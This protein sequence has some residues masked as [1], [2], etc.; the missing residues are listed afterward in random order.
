MALIVDASVAVKWF[1]A[2]DLHE[3]ARNLLTVDEPL[4]APDILATEFANVMWVKTRRREIEPE[5]AAR[6]LGA[7]VQ[8]VPL[9]RASVPLLPRA[10]EFA[11]V[12]DHPVYDC[13]YLALAHQ[14]AA[15]LVTADRRLLTAVEGSTL[16]VELRPLR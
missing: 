4:L 2:E 7:V 16:E 5:Q 9:L 3:V 11:G 8:G 13:V 12:L 6:A 10:L 15:P 1:V 14:L